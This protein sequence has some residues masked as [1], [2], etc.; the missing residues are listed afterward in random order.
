MT[1]N[2]MAATDGNLLHVKVIGTPSEEAYCSLTT[3]VAKH[4]RQYGKIRLLIEAAETAAQLNYPVSRAFW[5]EWVFHFQH[6]DDIERLALLGKTD[7]ALAVAVLCGSLTTAQIRHFGRAD[8]SEAKRWATAARSGS[9]TNRTRD[10]P[11]RPT[12]L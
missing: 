2:A 3:Q 10:G 9:S 5:E 1:E 7:W 8:V 11:S 12:G 6:W 4:V